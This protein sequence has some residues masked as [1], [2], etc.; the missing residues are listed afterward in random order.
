MNTKEK[1]LNLHKQIKINNSNYLKFLPNLN[2]QK[3]DFV[4]QFTYISKVI[5]FSKL[6]DVIS[7]INKIDTNDVLIE[8]KV[9]GMLVNL[10]YNNGLLLCVISKGNRHSGRDITRYFTDLN[11]VP[12]E[13]NIPFLIEIRG[14]ISITD[15]FFNKHYASEFIDSRSAISSK[16][17][18]K[19]LDEFF[20]KNVDIYVHDIGII[21]KDKFE[22]QINIY[23]SL[24]ENGFKVIMHKEIKD[25]IEEEINIYNKSEYLCDGIIFKINK[26]SKQIELLNESKQAK[27]IIALKTNQIFQSTVRNIEF[28]ISKDGNIVP[29]LDIDTI[30]C[31]DKKCNRISLYSYHKLKEDKITVGCIIRIR[32]NTTFVYDGVNEY[33]DSKDWKDLTHCISCKSPLKDEGKKLICTNTICK[34]KIVS[35]LFSY[36]KSKGIKSIGLSCIKLLVENGIIKHPI[37]VFDKEI[38]NL[39]SDKLKQ[40]NGYKNKK[41]QNILSGLNQ[42]RNNYYLSDLIML[43]CIP[44]IGQETACKISNIYNLNISEFS[45]DKMKNL[46]ILTKHQKENLQIF[47]VENEE[48]I[49]KFS[50]YIN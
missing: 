28:I 49:K 22:K 40:I 33:T 24:S 11:L 5:K 1:I 14:E 17:H 21:N 31:D 9:D 27:Y 7:F 44:T 4:P 13:I 23:S 43:L 32:Y 26:I 37:D 50:K 12:K 35:M 3:P 45:L 29:V 47:I 8:P 41:I 36:V 19:E 18:Q 39:I 48:L 10:I 46:D 42:I 2:L 15:E 30:Y 20:M 25:N 38:D 16:M 34:S 6:Q